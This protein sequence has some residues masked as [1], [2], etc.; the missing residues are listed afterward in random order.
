MDQLCQRIMA[1]MQFQPQHGENRSDARMPSNSS[2]RSS[3]ASIQL[4][5]INGS[6][7]YPPTP[8]T[9]VGSPRQPSYQHTFPQRASTIRSPSDSLSQRVRYNAPQASPLGWISSQANRSSGDL[10]VG[11]APS[12][13]GGEEQQSYQR[14]APSSIA[15]AEQQNYQRYASSSIA[16]TEQ[17]NYQ[18]YAPSSIAGEEQQ[19]YQRYAP[20]SIA[21]EEQQNYQGYA[22]SSIAGEEQQNIQS[23]D[24]LELER[25]SQFSIQLS[26]LGSDRGSVNLHPAS[27][28]STATSRYPHDPSTRGQA[29]SEQPPQ[30]SQQWTAPTD[31]AVILASETHRQNNGGSS[32]D[33][34]EASSTRS[35]TT[36]PPPLP[37]LETVETLQRYFEAPEVVPTDFEGKYPVTPG[38]DQSSEK[39]PAFRTQAEY[40]ERLL[41]L[42]PGMENIWMPLQRPAMHNRY[43]GFCKGAWQIR[44]MVR[45]YLRR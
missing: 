3:L 35:Q 12:S 36:R 32:G 40:T 16:G 18:R 38:P 37:R 44:K 13:I 4:S 45:S 43:Y 41:S 25:R 22:P 30:L 27:T 14:Y 10:T 34:A 29:P 8:P 11:Y 7:D 39:Y 26:T 23:P 15:G 24:D 2:M 21:G 6:Y 5:D 42:P 28:T 31:R 33:V 1:S 20:S 17:Q 19:N 9:S